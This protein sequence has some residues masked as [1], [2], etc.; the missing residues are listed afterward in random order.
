MRISILA[1]GRKQ[2]EKEVPDQRSEEKKRKRKFLIKY[3]KKTKEKESSRSN[4]RRK[5]RK[6]P[7]KDRMKMKELYKKVFGPDKYPN[8]TELSQP[9]IQ[10]SGPV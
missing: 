6:S 10:P 9:A 5:Q 2:K 3:W 8:N 7:I 1:L 4:I